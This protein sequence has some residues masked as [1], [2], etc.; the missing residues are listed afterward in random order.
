MQPDDLGDWRVRNGNGG[1]TPVEEI[2]STEW[3]YGSP[4]LQRFNGLSAV[5]IQG[6][7]APGVSSGV[8]MSE[9]ETLVDQLPGN[10]DLA[11]SGISAQEREAGS[12]ST[13]LYILSILFVFL[14]LAALYE[15]WI[16]PIAVLLTAPLG[17][18]GAVIA[19]QLRG[20]DNDIFFQVA[21][22]TT[23]GLASKNAILIVEFARDLERQGTELVEAVK[24]AVR[25]RFRPIMMTS[26]AF[27]FGVLPLALSTGAGAAGRV[28]VG[29]AVVGGLISAILLGLFFAPMFY[30]V[31]RKLAGGRPLKQAQPSEA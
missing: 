25:M 29:T 13:M 16:V 15:S 22:L 5:N 21:L 8:A 19:A 20:L 12:Q 4:Q 17:V 27:G 23:I 2:V 6:N 7:A 18:A 26:F 14:C 3:T 30:V 24:S 1:M 28:A 9:M 10:F 11:W 31:V